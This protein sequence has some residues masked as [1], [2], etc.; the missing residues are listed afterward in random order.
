MSKFKKYGSRMIVAGVTIILIIVIGL[1]ANGRNKITAVE[2]VIGKIITPIQ[3]FFY[4][5]GEVVVG[6][7]KSVE[8]IGNLEEENKR[9]E[10]ENARLIEMNRQYE[11]IIMR[12]DFLKNEADLIKNTKYTFVASQIIGKDSDNWFDRVIIDKG[13]KDGIKKDD[14][15]VQAVEIDEDIVIEGIIGRVVEVGDD[16]SKVISIIDGGSRLSFK[17]IR[18]QDG[19]IIR[20]SLEG[21]I[22]GYFFDSEADVVNGDKLLTSGLGGVF[23]E[24]LYIGTIENVE[25]KADEL[26]RRVKIKPAIDFNNVYKVYIITG[27]K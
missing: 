27:I 22:S 17:V 20:G 23:I 15:V 3:K 21:E 7:F 1:T 6:T 8:D 5:A 19:G 11:D 26:I 10:E 18:T 16:W 14:A 9:L 2:N 12:E 24:G 25:K 13:A 4:N